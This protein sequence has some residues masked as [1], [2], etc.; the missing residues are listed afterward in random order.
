MKVPIS[1]LKEYANIDIGIKEFCDG[2]TMSGSKVEG[3]RTHG[4]EVEKVIIGRILKIKE[5]PDADKLVIC[6][7]DTGSGAIQ[8]VT[9]AKNIKEGDLVPVALDGAKL[10][11]GLKIKKGKLRGE[12]SEG[13][14]CSLGEL[15]LTVNDYP[16]AIEDGIFVLEGDYETGTDINKALGLD[17]PVV[18]F[19]ITSNRPDCFSVIGLAREASVTFGADFKLEKPSPKASGESSIDDMVSIEVLDSELCPRYTAMAVT[20]VKIGHSP[21]WMRRR[22]RDAGVRPINNIVDITNYVM[23]EYGQPMHAFD[24]DMLGGAKIIVRRAEDGEKIMT[25]DDK[26][27]KLDSNM[28]V[29]AD[30]KRPMAVAGVMGGADSE[31]SPETRTIL[32]ESAN[33]ERTSVRLTAQKLSMRTES[34]GR[35]E[36]GLDINNTVPAVERACELVEILGAGKVAVGMIDVFAAIPEKEPVL[37]RPEK[38]NEFL[39][40]DISKVEMETILT[41]L[42]FDIVEKGVV[43]P[44]FRLDIECEA[45]IAEEVARFHGYNSIKATMPAGGASVIEGRSKAQKIKDEIEGI[46]LASGMF[47][48]YTFSFASPDIFDKLGLAEDDYRR[49]SVKIR[50][51]LGEDYSIMRTTALPDMIKVI[52]HNSNRNVEKGAFYEMSH[53]YHP[54]DG[55]LPL[56]KTVLT[57]GMYGGYDFYDL[58]GVIEEIAEKLGIG[59]MRFQ[60]YGK[61]PVYHPGRCAEVVSNSGRIGV[62]GQINPVLCDTFEVPERTYIGTF[63]IE[64]LVELSNDERYYNE[65]PKFPSVER[66]I[67]VLVKDEITVDDVKKVISG[68]G[69][70]NLSE[71]SFFDMYKGEQIGKGR[72]SLAFSLEFRSNERTLREEE[73]NK[74][75]DDIVA[76]LKEKLEAELR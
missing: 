71:V 27:R 8:V 52:S 38:I 49:K 10:P 24:L 2:M 31:V 14:L 59:D 23:L 76:S 60:A 54:V 50:N 53:I 41:S 20:D 15:N 12:V 74:S 70:A 17:D 39:G 55:R 26:P 18:E 36:K 4:D 66:D 29:I 51:P 46:C 30:E 34:S 22:L 63:D 44:S 67:A 72:K 16:H 7:V 13:M 3:Y 42:E 75:F 25:L 33:F 64:E 47:E 56:Q 43:P 37:F 69:G 1:W 48:I 40:T 57:L 32:F 6:E 61:D 35:F 28:L 21:E 65:L 73:V 9:G 68:A 62:F 45:D 5:H 11:G 58:K 19:E